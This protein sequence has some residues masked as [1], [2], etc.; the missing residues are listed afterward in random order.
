MPY[1]KVK[2]NEE[3][4]SMKNE[5]IQYTEKIYFKHEVSYKLP[6]DVYSMHT[7][8]VYELLYFL[9]G[10]AS[11]V[12]E[13]RKYKL[14]KGDL[15]LIRPFHYHYIQIDSCT[16]YERY[17]ILFDPLRDRIDGL[18]LLGEER[19]VIPILENT[20]AQNIFRKTD[21]YRE[22]CCKEQFEVLLPHMLSE[23][24]YSVGLFTDES[25]GTG[26]RLSP[27]ISDAL[28]YINRTICSI[29][30]IEEIAEHLFVSESYLFRRF[31][32]ELH[33]TPRRY[34][35]SKR[36]LLARQRLLLGEKPTEV[37]GKLGFGDYTAFYRNYK[38]FFGHAP[39]DRR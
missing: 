1:N 23:L 39:T 16:D 22:R 24:F 12:I 21:I 6:K 20:V 32:A 9:E 11:L 31:K 35:M 28:S 38:A 8:D 3:Q 2:E 29:R 37:S 13:D 14:N 18:E 4:K 19:E 15:I 26:K 5:Y 30:D 10:D 17:D 7:H 33:Q 36:L 25:F 34:I 27:L